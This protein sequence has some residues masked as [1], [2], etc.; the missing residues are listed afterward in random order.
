MPGFIFFYQ[1]NNRLSN[2]FYIIIIIIITI[3]LLC[4]F[5]IFIFNND[6]DF[7]IQIIGAKCSIYHN[8]E[9]KFTIKCNI[10]NN[11]NHASSFVSLVLIEKN[12]KIKT[13]VNINKTIPSNLQNNTDEVFIV[14][15]FINSFSQILLT[16]V[17]FGANNGFIRS[18]KLTK[19]ER[20]ILN[21]IKI[22]NE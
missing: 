6:K 19:K 20:K 12:N 18:R 11:S 17:P 3:I 1:Q 14:T 5:F 16:V 4:I 15:E 8:S 21:R 13:L 7:D 9:Y 10:I 22:Y 2:I